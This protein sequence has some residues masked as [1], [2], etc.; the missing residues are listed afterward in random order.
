V[1]PW[2]DGG[3]SESVEP[4]SVEERPASKQLVAQIAELQARLARSEKIKKT[5][6]ERVERSVETAGSA[7]TLFE[8]NILLEQ[9]VSQRTAE[10]RE[11]ETAYKALYDQSHL[12][13]QR[14]ETL[15]RLN[16]MADEP[17]TILC[18]FAMEEAVRLTGSTIGYLA[19]VSEDEKVLTMHAWSRS[20]MK[21][22]GSKINR[23]LSVENRPLKRSA[24][25]S[26]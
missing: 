7:Y 19:F 25:E 13:E 11:S 20:A 23:Y 26:P 1:W 5:L 16:Q 24:S 2:E 22:A 10:L 17:L 18:Q 4:H 3:V 9:S 12:N 6:M 14:L 21:N 8:R 15:Y